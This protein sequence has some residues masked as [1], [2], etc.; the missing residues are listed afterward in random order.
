VTVSG[1]TNNIML[2][3]DRYSTRSYNRTLYGGIT[4]QSQPT[5]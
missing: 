4:D 3:T 1:S 5:L 2:L